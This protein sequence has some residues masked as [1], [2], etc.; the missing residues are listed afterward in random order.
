MATAGVIPIASGQD[1]YVPYFEVKIEGRPQ[2]QNVIRDI[3]Q[4]SYKDN[5]KE[6][7]SFEITINNWDAATRKFKYSDSDLFDPGKELDLWMGYYGKNSL[8]LM[9]RGQITALRPSFPAGGGSTL[10]ISGLN[11]LH[12]LRTQQQTC[13]YEDMTDTEIAQQVG[14]RLGVKI[15]PT[16]APG[17]DKYKYI[18]QDNQYDI[19]F[20]MKRARRIGYDLIVEE[21]GENGQSQETVLRFQRSLNVRLITYQ[22]EYGRSLIEFKP[23]LTTA[24]QVGEVT[25]RGWDALNKK[26]IEYTA[27]RSEI[28][29][30]G[31]GSKGNQEAIE[32]SFKQRK[33]IVAT[34]PIESEAEAKTLAI[35]TLE[36]IAKDMIKGSGSTVGL[37]ELRAG[38]VIQID[39]LGE[40]FSGR[41]F[42]TSTT[43][44][45]GDSGYITQFECRREEI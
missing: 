28:G 10:S 36:E 17:E 43:H 11:L 31:V 45:I 23:D 2:G 8:R 38:N 5:I 37:T 22:L 42:I 24:N 7:D 3:L 14:K 40:R 20:L 30:K 29:V 41:Y 35:R 26:K 44:S 15:L 12:K 16:S 13:A 19:I 9:I 27:K 34:K 4:V 39:G 18:L 25:V 6:I 33:E 32:Q 1:F 21:K